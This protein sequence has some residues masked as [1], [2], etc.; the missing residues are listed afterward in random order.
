MHCDYFWENRNL[1]NRSKIP[2]LFEGQIRFILQS[3]SWGPSD[4]CELRVELQDVGRGLLPGPY[5]KQQEQKGLVTSQ[6]VYAFP[7]SIVFLF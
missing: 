3:A 1:G 6:S 5:F 4:Y 7:C 2:T